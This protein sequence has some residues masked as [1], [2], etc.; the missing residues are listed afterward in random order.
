[1]KKNNSF[2]LFFFN[3]SLPEHKRKMI[4][5]SPCRLHQYGV[6]AAL[7]L[8]L[9]TVAHTAAAAADEIKAGKQYKCTGTNANTYFYPTNPSDT[10]DANADTSYTCPGK[11]SLCIVNAQ[12]SNVGNCVAVACNNNDFFIWANNDVWTKCSDLSG[13]FTNC[14]TSTCAGSQQADLYTATSGS[15]APSGDYIV[16]NHGY[17]AN[18]KNVPVTSSEI[19]GSPYT[20]SAANSQ[21]YYYASDTTKT[22]T[23]PGSAS[24]CE[25]GKEK[26]DLDF[27]MPAA[28]DAAASGSVEYYYFQGDN[29]WVPCTGLTGIKGCVTSAT[30]ESGSPFAKLWATK[31][32]NQIPAGVFSPLDGHA[33]DD[34][35]GLNNAALPP[36][37]ISSSKI[38]TVFTLVLAVLAV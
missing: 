14:P 33:T 32:A 34:T 24:T 4:M 16:I 31:V 3:K 18:D 26:D 7:L 12:D 2:L 22:Y 30:C 10:Y 28:C 17:A 5:K 15:S 1:M 21:T 9:L 19:L 20:C 36:S 29:A 35:V 37:L 23:C 11:A 6:A 25:V 27:C 38:L 13:A 8:S